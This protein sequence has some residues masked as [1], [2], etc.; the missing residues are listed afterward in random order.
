V[1]WPV[2]ALL[3]VRV[4]LSGGRCMWSLLVP[5][6]TTHCFEPQP[7]CCSLEQASDH[8]LVL[9]VGLLIAFASYAPVFK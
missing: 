7:V 2:C 9:F 1:G 3:L 4:F 8:P 5:G 6:K